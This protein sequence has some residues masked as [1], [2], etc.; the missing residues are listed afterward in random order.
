[1]IRLFSHTVEFENST[2]LDLVGLQIWR[3]ALILADFIIHNQSVFKDKVVLE[4]GSGTGLSSVVSAFYASKV[5]ATGM[6]HN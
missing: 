5:V 1:L 4:V 6:I 3:G 2:T